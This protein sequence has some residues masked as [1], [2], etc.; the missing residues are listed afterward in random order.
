VE[1]LKLVRLFSLMELTSGRPEIVIGLLDGPVAVNHP[2]LAGSIRELPGDG[3]ADGGCADSGSPACEHGTFIAGILAGHRGG[4]APAIC[5]GCTVL[6]RPIF[7]ERVAHEGQP[8]CAAPRDVAVA[9]VECVDAG[10]RALNLSA[11]MAQP[12]VKDERELCDALN[13]AARRGSL[14]VV[15]AGNQG[16]VG[17]SALTRHPWVI[18]AVGYGADGRPMA[19]SNLGGSTARR[20]LGAP[21]EDVT[22]LGPRGKPVARTGTSP[23]AAFVTGTV[24]LLWSA[25]PSAHAVEVKSAV[26]GLGV[27]GSR[28][29]GIAP[30]LLDALAAYNALSAMRKGEMA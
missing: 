3:G 11:G 10:A 15:A 24:A 25:F 4:S 26:L 20:G 30:P 23:A 27:R 29:V 21:G 5:P 1:P 8:P 2:D 14:V 12:S 7:A 28:R 19:L 18:P 22:S 17:S 6:V 16:A 13:H 9:I